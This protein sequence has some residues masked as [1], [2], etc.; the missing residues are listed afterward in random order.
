MRWCAGMH[1]TACQCVC[2]G[3]CVEGW[4]CAQLPIFFWKLVFW[5]RCFPARLRVSLTSSMRLTMTI[6]SCLTPTKLNYRWSH[7]LTNEYSK[8]NP[9]NGE[10]VLTVKPFFPE[11]KETSARGRVECNGVKMWHTP[12]RD[13]HTETNVVT[14]EAECVTSPI[15]WL[16]TV[17]C[18]S[19]EHKREETLSEFSDFPDDATCKTHVSKLLGGTYMR[20]Y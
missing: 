13:D 3:A 20:V 11:R 10:L 15:G 17:Q 7:S 9:G 19:N 6:R 12:P 8:W 2:V 18:M 16:L 1:V 5:R 14:Y 4:V